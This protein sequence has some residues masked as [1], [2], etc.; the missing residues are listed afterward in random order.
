VRG[1]ETRGR[2]PGIFRLVYFLGLAAE[3][4]IRIPHERRRREI[5]MEID[6]ADGTERRLIGLLF[7]GMFVLPA[8]TTLLGGADYRLSGRGSRRAGAAGVALLVSSI[9]VFWR[10]H[11]DLGRNWSPSLQLRNEHELVVRGVYRW[12]RHP[13]YASEW[14]WGLAQALLLQNWISGPASLASF[15]PLYLSRVPREERM[16]LERFGDDYH[17]YMGRTGRILP[18]LRG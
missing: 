3:T 11:T 4:A 10:S 12:V 18:R 15:L 5:R 6:R 7:L 14:L 13:M 16:M 2:L 8:L 17:A 9:W 1:D